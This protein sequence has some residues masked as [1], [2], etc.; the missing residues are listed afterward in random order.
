MQSYEKIPPRYGGY[1]R[2]VAPTR[3]ELV[4]EPSASINRSK[5]QGLKRFVSHYEKIP[6]RY[7]GYFRMVAPTR[8]E[9]VTQGSSGLCS[10]N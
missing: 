2:V 10:T 8:L 5:G 7:G 6:P 3:L 4:T 1:F 9:L